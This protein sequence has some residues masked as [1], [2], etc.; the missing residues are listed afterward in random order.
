MYIGLAIYNSELRDK[1]RTL[2]IKILHS[3]LIFFNKTDRNWFERTHYNN[4]MSTM[5]VFSSHPKNFSI[6]KPNVWTS[7][8][9]R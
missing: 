9:C 2:G 1:S 5:G 7:I 3:R 8:K 4:R 6:V